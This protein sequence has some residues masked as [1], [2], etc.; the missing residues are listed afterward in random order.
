MNATQLLGIV[1]FGIAG[2]L[3]LSVRRSPWNIIGS[4]NLLYCLECLVGWRHSLH[5][6]AVAAMGDQYSERLPLQIALL[7]G[8]L[9]VGLIVVAALLRAY[10][11]RPTRVAIGGTSIGA[12]LF[13]VEAIS[14]HEI[15]RILYTPAGPALL[16]AWVWFGSTI[17]TGS[18]AAISKL[19][20]RYN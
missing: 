14:L 11:D 20:Q 17:A 15:D 2:V 18:A 9:F 16:I 3:C 6:M 7:G 5:D 13:L 1:S 12:G 4:S 19:R 8:G 10:D